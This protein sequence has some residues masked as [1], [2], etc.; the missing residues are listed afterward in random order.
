[1]QALFNIVDDFEAATRGAGVRGDNCSVR[2]ID[3]GFL[4]PS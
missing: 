1:V 4:L 2:R 3:S